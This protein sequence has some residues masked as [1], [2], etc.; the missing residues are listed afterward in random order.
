M[1]SALGTP[2]LLLK[3]SSVP[4][5]TYH[6]LSGLMAVRGVGWG[7]RKNFFGIASNNIGSPTPLSMKKQRLLLTGANGF[8]GSHLI[9]R[10]EDGVELLKVPHNHLKNINTL[11][12]IVMN[13]QPT[14]IVHMASYG[15]LASQTDDAETIQANFMNLYNLLDASKYSQY[16]VFINFSTSS[17]KL[18]HDTM[19]SATK[20]GGER[21]C[22]AWASK[23]NRNI[24]SV[25]PYTVIG[26]G[27]PKEHL[28]PTLIRSCLSGDS[29]PFV[30][31]PVHDFVN[32]EDFISALKLVIEDWH[33]KGV[34]EIGTGIKTS[35][36]EI[37][38]IVEK[39][40][41]KKA[42]IKR[43]DNLRSYDNM[44][45]VANPTIIQSLGWKPKFTIKDTIMQMVIEYEKTKNKR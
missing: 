6:L 28:I 33:V 10:L 8:I 13:F 43:V 12:G 27:E 34:V 17:V 37:L 11:K 5:Y 25:E 19:Y 24:I 45:W 7:V 2:R 3:Q 30:G 32:V 9:N 36:E 44:K 15:N 31:S 41:G 1:I 4:A 38:K 14:V 20:A 35:N 26:T 40:T 42:N 21:L 22:R 18:S 39:V 23:Y 16:E 29:M